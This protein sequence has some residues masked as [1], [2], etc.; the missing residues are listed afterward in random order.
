VSDLSPE[1]LQ[2]LISLLD[3]EDREVVRHVEEKIL[4][5]GQEIIPMLEQKWE[6]SFNPVFQQRVEELIHHLQFGLVK[7]RILEWAESPEQD[8]LQGLWAIA[9]YSYPDLDVQSLRKEIEQ[10]YYEV[11]TQMRDDLHPYDLIKII[12]SVLY[13][14]L[15]FTSN[16]KNFHSPGNSMI[17]VVL[18]SKKGNPIALACV[19]LLVAQRLQLPIYGVNLP[20]LFVLTY[21]KG[22]MQFYINAFNRGLIFS[23]KEIEQYI[24]QLRL[25]M[26]E[27]Y[28]EPCAP[29]DI[30]TRILRNLENA[31]ER[32]GDPSKQQEVAEL[33]ALLDAKGEK[34]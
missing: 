30:I 5:M 10:I 28:Y 22:D 14:K 32:L 17:N 15:K 13:N 2:A 25:P 24:R 23:K 21:K 7:K 1:A 18:N 6:E 12:N 16:T 4:D 34:H 31:Y 3:D 29:K 27:A 9:T 26:L 33:L 19:Y 11:W 8:V 20:S